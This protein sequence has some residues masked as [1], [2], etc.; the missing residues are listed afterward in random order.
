MT[1]YKFGSIW[2][3]FIGCILFWLITPLALAAGTG[4]LDLHW[5]IHFLQ[6]IPVGLLLYGFFLVYRLQEDATGSL[7]LFGL[8]ISLAGMFLLGGVDILQGIMMVGHTETLPAFSLSEQI[9]PWGYMC[10]LLGSLAFGVATLRAALLPKS[11]AWL[12]ILGP[13]LLY[14]GFTF[15]SLFAGRLPL[16]EVNLAL[17]ILFAPTLAG[18]FWLGIGLRPTGVEA[19]IGAK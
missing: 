12:C 4:N 3:L 19:N 13:V 14:G 5:T 10:W 18:W 16:T 11:G 9:Y 6:A 7:A 15:L 2:P 8:L 1:S 17:Y